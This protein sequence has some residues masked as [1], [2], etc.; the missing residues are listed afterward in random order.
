ML[1]PKSAHQNQD[2]RDKGDGS[3]IGSDG[4]L[5]VAWKSSAAFTRL[6]MPR[7]RPD[8]AGIQRQEIHAGPPQRK[9]AIGCFGAAG[10]KNR[11]LAEPLT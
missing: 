1:A 11:V 7:T 8:Q 5:A 4:V 9:D 2:L 10:D 3:P 6:G